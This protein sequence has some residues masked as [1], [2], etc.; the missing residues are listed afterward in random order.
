MTALAL[1]TADSLSDILSV[2]IFGALPLVIIWSLAQRRTNTIM[3]WR[4]DK[5]QALPKISARSILPENVE[6]VEV[7]RPRIRRKTDK[8]R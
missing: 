8:S 5:L 6:L 2:E 4:G 7:D 3:Q 1:A